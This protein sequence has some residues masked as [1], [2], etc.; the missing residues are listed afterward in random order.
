V[1][2]ASNNI[3]AGGLGRDTLEGGLGD[4]IYVLSDS[5]DTIMDTG[6]NDTIRSTLDISL[7]TGME[8]AELTGIGDTSALGN[9][10]NNRLV[11]NM[12]DNTL[13]GGK[14]VDTLSGGLGSD[15]FMVAYNGVGI[16][17]DQITDFVAAEDLLVVD[18]A[19]LGLDVAQMALLSSGTVDPASFVKGAGAKAVDN[20]DYFLFDTARAMLAFDPDGSGV[21]PS[22]DLVNLF[23]T[24]V[25]NLTAND[26]YLAV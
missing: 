17:V 12:G 1:G 22:V 20:N 10:A 14:G 7:P 18:L 4:D 5:L 11:G 15:Q 8:N 9:A 26:I 13:D 6:G 23:G 2:N 3:L 16:A 24:G 21:R 19:S 25:S